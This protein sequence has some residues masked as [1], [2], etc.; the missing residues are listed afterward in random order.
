MIQVKQLDIRRGS[1]LIISGISFE[2]HPGKITAVLGANGAGKTTLLESLTGR[3]PFAA[4]RIQWDGLSLREISA[5]EQAGRRAVLSQK[6]ELNFPVNVFDLVEMG[7]YAQYRHLKTSERQKLVN[8]VLEQLDLQDF[9]DRSFQQLSGGEQQ[10]VLL[11][12]CI[13][14]LASSSARFEHQY[15]F[16]DEPTNNLDIEQQ[17]RLM[18]RVKTLVREQKLGVLAIVHDLN[19]AAQFAD[20]LVLIKNGKIL[21]QGTPNDVMTTDVLQATFNIHSIIRR[22]PLLD[23]PLITVIPYEIHN[24]SKSTCCCPESGTTPHAQTRSGQSPFRQ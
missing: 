5:Q 14:Q 9:R 11:A 8:R 1:K 2:V 12:K 10:R 20:H 24:Q 7:T 3:L 21:F 18:A 6:L 17:Y 22:H 19:L 4:G 23:C 16:L 15:L 13:T